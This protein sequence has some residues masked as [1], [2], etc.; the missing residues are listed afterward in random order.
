MNFRRFIM[1]KIALT[2]AF[3]LTL[4]S[5]TG[6]KDKKSEKADKSTSSSKSETT[7]E[8]TTEAEATEAEGN[9]KNADENK[10]NNSDDNEDDPQEEDN[11]DI[12]FKRGKIEDGVYSNEFADIKFAAPEGWTFA[13]DEYILKMMNISLDKIGDDTAITQELLDQAVIYDAFCMDQTTGKNIIFEFENLEKEVPN[14]DEYTMDDI[15]A[16][17]DQQLAAIDAIEYKKVKTDTTT[18]AGKEYTRLVY[19][20]DMGGVISIEQVFYIRRDGN[21]VFCII[22][23]NGQS[24]EDMTTYEDKFETLS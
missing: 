8:T 7:D 9:S 14:P 19:Q 11:D 6:C 17:F 20:A 2:L 23:S 16:A 24:G 4:C 22:A 13:D 15:I 3:I 10:E 5:F 18:I 1:K 12:N 21:L